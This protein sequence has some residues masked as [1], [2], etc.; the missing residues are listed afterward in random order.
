MQRETMTRRTIW[1]HALGGGLG[2]CLNWLAISA[3]GGAAGDAWGG[4]GPEQAQGA[5]ARGRRS[6]ASGPEDRPG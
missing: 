6:S 2:A 3:I 1:E 4:D 5:T